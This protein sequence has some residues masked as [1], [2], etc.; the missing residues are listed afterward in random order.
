MSKFQNIKVNDKVIVEHGHRT[1]IGTV[2]SVG[3]NQLSIHTTD[4][5]LST[6]HVNDIEA[7]AILL[8][9]VA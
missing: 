4:D 8:D 6:Y 3:A 2:T 7:L 5:R 1:L 9:P